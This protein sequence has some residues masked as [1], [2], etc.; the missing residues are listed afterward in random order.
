MHDS[1][2]VD[3]A[4]LAAYIFSMMNVD[5]ENVACNS[6]ISWEIGVI[7]NN[8]MD[9]KLKLKWIKSE[10]RISLFA[11]FHNLTL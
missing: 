9:L 2:I 7:N 1:T 8:C 11:R 6:P 10:I 4:V 5:K 3:C